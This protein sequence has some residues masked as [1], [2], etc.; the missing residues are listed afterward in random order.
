MSQWTHITACISV[1]TCYEEPRR[2]VVR[3]V[4]TDLVTA[5]KITGSEHDA[6]IFINVIGGYN[7]WTSC[8]CDHC[9]KYGA[10]RKE[11]AEGFECDAPDNYKCKKGQYQSQ[12]AISI[13]GDLRDR[14]KI[15]TE[16]EFQKFFEY[17]ANK[18][19]IRDYSINIEGE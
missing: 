10:T 5:P 13:Q 1:D 18:Y 6:N 12:V 11:T 16:K 15:E 14:T 2:E 3:L 4:K 7:S 9:K 19:I 17:I 8:D